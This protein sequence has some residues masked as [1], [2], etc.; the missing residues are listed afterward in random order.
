MSDNKLSEL[1]EIEK[2]SMSLQNLNILIIEKEERKSKFKD[3]LNYLKEGNSKDLKF[4]YNFENI[5]LKMSRKES[6]Q[7]CEKEISK[8]MKELVELN[9]TFAELKIKLVSKIENLDEV[10]YDVMKIIEKDFLRKQNNKNKDYSSGQIIE[11]E[12]DD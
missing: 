3:F 1:L 9:K 6:V 12:E 10:E 11:E 7:S 8:L 2:T 4:L 5:F